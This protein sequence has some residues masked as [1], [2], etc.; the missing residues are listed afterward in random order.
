MLFPAGIGYRTDTVS[1]A[2]TIPDSIA[3]LH[4]YDKNDGRGP[5]RIFFNLRE[6]ASELSDAVQPDCVA[7]INRRGCN[8]VPWGEAV[9]TRHTGPAL[10]LVAAFT[11]SE[12]V[13]NSS[14]LCVFAPAVARF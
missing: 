6:V 11:N 12:Q 1:A 5:L 14:P 3:T 8:W 9:L 13:L 4:E 10:A 2:D 7:Y